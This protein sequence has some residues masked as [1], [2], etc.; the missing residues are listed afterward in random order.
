MLIIYLLYKSVRAIYVRL[1]LLLKHLEIP[2]DLP[3]NLCNVIVQFL[4]DILFHNFLILPL[5]FLFL[6][7]GG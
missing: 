3:R 2:Y 1:L 6:Y 4:A 5:L 7:V